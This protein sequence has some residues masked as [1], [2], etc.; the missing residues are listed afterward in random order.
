LPES[1]STII[2]S[3]A[4][5]R[6]LARLLLDG[7]PGREGFLFYDGH[8]QP[9]HQAAPGIL[10]LI[11][12]R[13]VMERW[14][15]KIVWWLDE[16]E[17]FFDHIFAEFHDDPAFEPVRLE[18]KEIRALDVPRPARNRFLFHQL[19]ATS[20][21][22][23]RS[24]FAGDVGDVGEVG[25]AI[26]AGRLRVTAGDR[27]TLSLAGA[28]KAH[29]RQGPGA[30]AD[31]VV[32]LPLNWELLP[33][34]EDYAGTMRFTRAFMLD[35]LPEGRRLILRFHG[36]DYFTDL[37]V[38][39]HY[40]GGHE[41]Y[42][43]PFEFDISAFLRPGEMNILRLA[44]TSPNDPSG[45]GLHVT[46]AWGDFVHGFPNRKTTVKGTLGHHDARRGGAWSAVTSQD[47]NTGGVWDELELRVA[48]PVRFTLP[49]PRIT[50]LAADAVPTTEE[51]SVRLHLAYAITNP[52]GRA[53]AAR[54]RLL[55][56]PANFEGERWERS[57]DV[58][59]GPEGDDVEVELELD[60]VRLWQPRDHGFPHL[61]RVTSILDVDAEIQDQAV[62]E[63]GFRTLAVSPIGESEGVNGAFVLNG[64]RVFVRG[65]NLL[66][67]YWLSEYTPER[68]ERDLAMLSGA[69]FNAV[70]V[71][72]LV[73]PSHFYA[74]ANRAGFLV[75]QIFPLQWSYAQSGEFQA[76][77][78]EQIREM[79]Q[80]LMNEP[81]VVSYEVHNEP[82]MRTAAD[83]DN[84]LMDFDLH[85]ALRDADP[86]RW[87]TTFSSG[88]HAYP[89]QFYSLRD[90]NSFATLPA[91]FLE[92]DVHGRRIARHRNMPTEFGIQAMPHRELFAEL[93]SED[94]MRQVLRRIR[95]DSKWV[96]GGGESWEAAEKTIEEANAVLGDGTWVGTLDALDWTLLGE[97]G[98][99]EHHIGRIECGQ[100]QLSDAENR[101]LLSCRVAL[102][103]LDVLHYGGF[104][105]ENFWFGL[106]R[107]A[108]SLDEF[109]VSSQDRQYRL[110]KDAI[111]MYLNASV[112]GPIVGYFSFMFRDADWEAPTWGVVDA[113]WVPKKAYRAYLESNHPV[114][115]SLPHAL[116]APVKFPGDPWFT[117]RGDEW[118]ELR[119]RW[120]AA[121]VIV[122][123]D[124]ARSLG[125][126]TVTIW[127]EDADGNVVPFVDRAGA[128]R[129]PVHLTVDV[130]AESGWSGPWPGAGGSNAV[131]VPDDIAPGTYYL[132][133]KVAA[134]EGERASTNS[135]EFV[136]LDTDFAELPSFT[137]PQVKALLDGA[138]ATA[139]FHYWQHGGAAYRARPGLR[140]LVRGF[141]DARTRGVDLYEVVQGEHLFRHILHELSHLPQADRLRDDIWR[142]RS[143]VVSPREKA[144][145]L[146]RY[147]ELF[148][149]QAE[150]RLAQLQ[151]ARR[152]QPVP[153]TAEPAPEA[154]TTPVAF[155][156]VGRDIPANA[157]S[158][159]GGPGED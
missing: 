11:E 52:A 134:A 14:K 90:D 130:D 6:R 60:G 33:G 73:A 19:R 22:L 89:G 119:E 75:V 142:I 32:D 154:R 135:Y 63:T 146:L 133:A 101:K 81:S 66:P 116:R 12:G 87:A 2:P 65:T 88:N 61:Y 64:R 149:H 57:K 113:A 94:R 79:A 102:L 49:G 56:E 16:S 157:T 145:A 55:I 125:P 5:S 103:L 76:R 109:V 30:Y 144:R 27:S 155:P 111:E 123:N 150:A 21:E 106:W 4:P 92:D 59:V 35:D 99:L 138:P 28:W 45:T 124:T 127:L 82:D 117:A 70:L 48:N 42:F 148:V 98:D 78:T 151:R 105:G 91:R 15:P 10:G 54:I 152:P 25:D 3:T 80:L 122:G 153:P 108:R 140:G 71:H 34:I 40:V 53:Q 156:P 17:H 51:A 114:R 126:A 96:A 50:T 131:V 121:D 141:R 118:E 13:Q 68:V 74:Q 86:S 31:R 47:G 38:N 128:S 132:K 7:P 43:A 143:E 158:D 120:L 159:R 37:W 112:V 44:V 9:V 110:H 18:L 97:L 93:L 24:L 84:R 39:G 26:D 1:V 72:A 139:G 20:R 147:A 62:V 46:S 69:G 58:V 85:I 100:P 8:N 129:D 67:T 77:A 95:T 36:V 115:V 136:V 104:K 83:L 41:G 107:P 29:Y 23:E 137:K